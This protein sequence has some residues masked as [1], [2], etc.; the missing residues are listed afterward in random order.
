MPIQKITREEILLKSADVFRV[1]G[2]HN[3]SMQDLAE[4]CGLLKG[5]L[6]Y[7]FPSKEMLMKDL[8]E[9][10]HRLLMEKIFPIAQDEALSPEERM[11]K[12]LKKMGKLLLEKEG[13]CLI[14]NTTLETVG[15]VPEFQPVLRTIMD[16]WTKALQTIFVNKKSPEQSFRLAQQT[17]MEFEGATMFTKLYGDKQF[18]YDTFARTMMKLN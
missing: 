11:E 9:S 2:Y 15:V 7:H 5:S 1:K 6:Y 14:G 17:I 12:L 10:I 13:G 3:T 16:D 18:L 4:A 8:L